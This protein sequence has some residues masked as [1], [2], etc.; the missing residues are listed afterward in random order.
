MEVARELGRRNLDGYLVRTED[1][2]I[3]STDIHQEFWEDSFRASVPAALR[4]KLVADG[5]LPSELGMG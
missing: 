1:F 3:F 5:W 2:A 4:A